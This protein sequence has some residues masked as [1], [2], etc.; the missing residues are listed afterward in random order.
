MKLHNIIKANADFAQLK[1]IEIEDD[2][3]SSLNHVHKFNEDLGPVLT[4]EK[5]TKCSADII[6]HLG[7]V[8]FGLSSYVASQQG[9][10]VGSK[11]SPL[12][13]ESQT[14]RWFQIASI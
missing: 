11:T 12:K 1:E 3:R 14:L 8:K 13:G 2:L 9:K 5:Y 4:M 7:T 10:L 6:F